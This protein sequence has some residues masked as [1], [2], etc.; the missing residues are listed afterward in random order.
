MGCCSPRFY[1]KVFSERTA[2]RD[3]RRYRKKGLK[4]SERD[5]VDFLRGRAETVLEVGGG[6]GSIDVE[7]LKGGAAH[8]MIVELSPSYEAEA[9][10]LAEEARIGDR[11]SYLVAN[12]VEKDLEHADAVVMHRVVCCYPDGEVLVRRAAVHARRHLLVTFPRDAP[13]VRVGLA[14]LNFGMWAMRL[15]FRSYLHSPDAL[16]GA[17]EG[18]RV[19]HERRG[20]VWQLA[21]LER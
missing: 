18:M 14:F 8:A 9:R 21:V 17:A 15:R 4:A 3:A 10:S 1:G 20:R 5:V 11:L 12:I 13:W 2:R 7:L 19:V 16:L 6:I